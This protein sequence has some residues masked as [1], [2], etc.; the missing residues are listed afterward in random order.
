MPFFLERIRR[1]GDS[2]AEIR[3]FTRDKLAAR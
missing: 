3:K 1:R 2:Q